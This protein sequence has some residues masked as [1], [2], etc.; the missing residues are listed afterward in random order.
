[1]T[2]GLINRRGS[3]GSGSDAGQPE[4]RGGQGAQVQEQASFLLL[5]GPGKPEPQRP[6]LPGNSTGNTASA[7]KVD[8]ICIALI[9]L[10]GIGAVLLRQR[11]ADFM[12]EDAFYGDAAMSIL[13]HGYYGV[14]GVSETTQPP[15]LAGILAILYAMFGYSY[16][17]SVGAMAVFETL[18]FL[19]AYQVLQRRMPR[20]AAAAI[21]ILL[22]SSPVY[23]AWATRLV[24]ACY[25]Y[26]FTTMFALLA[27]DEYEKATAPRRRIVWGILLAAAVVA[28]LLIATGTLALLGA[29]VAAI[30]ATALKDR[31]LAR[32]RLLQFLPILLLGI[33]VQVTWSHRRP[34][35]LEWSLPGYPASY[36]NQL[37][38]KSGNHPELGLAKLRDIPGR[39]ETNLL[40]ESDIVAQLVLRHGANPSK[41]AVVIIPALLVLIGW[42]FS[43]WNSGATD[44]VDWYFAG[45]QVVYLLWPWTMEARFVLPVA[46]LACLYLWRGVKGAVFA[47]RS[48]PRVVGIIWTPISI[49]LTVSGAQWLWLHRETGYGD[50][51]DELIVPAWL[52]G[53][54][55]FFWM[56]WAGKSPLPTDA[57]SRVG[58]WLERP[59]G[60]SR[61]RPLDAAHY[62]GLAAVLGLVLIGIRVEARIGHENLKTTDLQHNDEF[63]EVGEI[64]P[65]EVEAGM[66]LRANTPVDSVVMARHWPTVLHYADRK[67]IWFPPISDPTI[68]MEGI[69]RH[70]VQYIVVVNH[71]NAYYLPDDG[72]CFDQLMA[73][74]GEHF[75]PVLRK[76]NFQIFRVRQNL[77]L[78]AERAALRGQS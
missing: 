26:F 75:E 63:T 65:A 48:T 59:W 13:H 29:M 69:E 41:V 25:P 39:L 77:D 27:V 62:A 28:S 66:W 72:Y 45:Y 57:V 55:I 74:F 71:P 11:T 15:G 50:F 37:R 22:L 70:K 34:A 2:E 19:A 47:L 53:A 56:A 36:W 38:A 46:P 4:A 18:G 61:I 52:I 33:A 12:G 17:L 60:D 54:G 14:N 1:M 3:G 9:V 5:G 10:F 64:M 58:A 7:R 6:G 73:Q 43:F 31:R 23:F 32:T 20:L 40:Y 76:A 35:P 51:P 49:L 78:K 24:Y 44:M 8:L 30:G 68:L 16:A 21:C 42:G 67:L